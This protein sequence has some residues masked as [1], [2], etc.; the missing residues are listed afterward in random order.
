MTVHDPVPRVTIDANVLVVAPLNPVSPPGL[1]R[2]AWE[3]GRFR[4]VL[5]E[6]LLD[7][8]IRTHRKPFF[9]ARLADPDSDEYVDL[10]RSRATIV[11]ITASVQGVATHPEDN[12]I[13][14]TAISG[15]VDY[16][17]TG[18]ER[19]RSRVPTY[20]GIQVVSPAQFVALLGLT[21]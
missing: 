1:I 14:A 18:D 10:L 8:V 11:Q 21:P 16:R 2:Q 13:L 20:Q 19:L 5:S 15:N 3:D 4:L 7:E 6:H 17:V 9:R 12:L